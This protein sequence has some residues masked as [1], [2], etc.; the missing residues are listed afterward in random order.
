MW[1][2]FGALVG[3]GASFIFGDLLTLPLDLYYLIYFGVIITFFAIYIKKT[4]LA[5]KEWL[6]RR[7]GW[8]ILLGLIFG[9][10]M[11]QNVL[12]RPETEKFTGAYLIWAIFWRG[13]IYGTID[14]L[15][16]FVFP[17]IVTWRAFN[18][19]QKPLVRR[20]GFGLL[21]WLF[22]LV[23]TTFYHLGYSDFRSKKI[24][25]PNIGSTIMSVPTLV[26]GSPI[27]STLTHV[28]MHITAVVHSPDTELF[29]PPHRE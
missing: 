24:I 17:W 28:V 2:A 1:I 9:A 23:I 12:S 10:L 8:G 29:L 3:F 25:Q 4:K 7:L 22:I 18:V 15:L 26:S 27:G 11:L 20:I 16:L 13:L 5:L 19:G 21:A 6:S 14:G